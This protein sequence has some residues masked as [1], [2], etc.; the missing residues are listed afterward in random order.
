MK[1]TIS[2]K[3]SWPLPRRPSNH[4]QFRIEDHA[5]IAVVFLPVCV[6][7]LRHTASKRSIN[8]E[9]KLEYQK[10]GANKQY[11]VKSQSQVFLSHV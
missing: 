9:Q 7:Y 6:S 1:Y 4:T 5:D 10:M 2:S 8:E 11:D 3:A